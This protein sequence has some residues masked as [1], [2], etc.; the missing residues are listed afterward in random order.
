MF[1]QLKTEIEVY[2][3]AAKHPRVP[4]ISRFLIGAAVAYAISPIDLIPD[5]IPVVGHLD[6]ILVIPLLIWLAL[7]WTPNDILDECRM[8]IGNA[9]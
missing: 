9:K 8:Q 6:D 7:R 1:K 3:L 5:F 4:W 2:R